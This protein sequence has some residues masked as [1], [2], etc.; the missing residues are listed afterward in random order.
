MEKIKIEKRN[1]L[2]WFFSICGMIV[3]VMNLFQPPLGTIDG[4]VLAFFGEICI[5]VGGLLGIDA[6]YAKKFNDLLREIRGEKKP[7]K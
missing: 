7:D 5:L 3:V 4:S 1:A 2:A 6:I